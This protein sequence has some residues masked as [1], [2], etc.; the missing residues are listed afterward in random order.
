MKPVITWIVIADGA[1][2]RV[3]ENTGPGKGLSSLDDLIFEG[4]HLPTRD[5]KSD[6]SGRTF[7]SVGQ[8]RHAL[9]PTSDPSRQLKAA[10]AAG[11]LDALAERSSEFDR[12][13]LV[14]PPATLGDLREALPDQLTSKVHGELA[15][16][17]TGIPNTEL[18]GH[19][20]SLIAL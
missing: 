2:A 8:P 11:I 15:K 4:E 17:L 19:L 13:I 9:Q 12:L 5:L 1:R 10:F 18:D 7:E 6:K 20:N 16:D 3:L 14:A